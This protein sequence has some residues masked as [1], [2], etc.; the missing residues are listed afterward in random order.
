MTTIHR[1]PDPSRV[2]EEASRWIARLNADDVT[3]ADRACFAAWRD[4]HPAHARAYEELSSTWSEL[5]NAGPWV[6]A[7]SF[8]QSMNEA[9]GTAPR[10]RTFRS[11]PVLRAASTG[12]AVLVLAILGAFYFKPWVKINRYTTAVGEHATISLEDGSTLELNSGSAATVDYSKAA[13]VIHLERG[14]GYFQV[15]HDPGRPFWVVGGRT[16]VRAVGTA[17]NVYLRPDQVQV[18]VTD[19]TVKVGST[20]ALAGADPSDSLIAFA[21]VAVLKAGEQADLRE[22]ATDTRKLTAA[23]VQRAQDWREGT[24]YFENEP[25]QKV[26]AELNRYTATKLIIEDARLASVP[27]GGTFETTPNG[28]D[29]LLTMLEQG[30]GVRV[31]R[32][33]DRV[34]IDSADQK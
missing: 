31:R 6:R 33:G 16:W 9:A 20:E 18:T 19:G 11:S 27:V 26:I 23:E 5:T 21:H 3:S 29:S 28:V 12:A 25:L 22:F 2:E 17:F 32:D 4:A 34:L 24:L 7:V 10:Q 15:A 14:E 1:I 8:A 30:F 13:R